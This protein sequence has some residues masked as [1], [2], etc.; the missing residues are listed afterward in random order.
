MRRKLVLLFY[1]A[2]LIVSGCIPVSASGDLGTNTPGSESSL[3]IMP[4]SDFDK[5]VTKAPAMKTTPS[6]TITAVLFIH[7]PH[8]ARPL[9]DGEVFEPPPTLA[10]TPT[11]WE[12][13]SPLQGYPRNR[14]DKIVS[15]PYDPPPMGSDDRH[16]GVDFAYHSLAGVSGSIEGVGV[17]SVMPGYVAT[18]IHNSFPFG[19]LVII[20]TP[21]ALVPTPV[22]QEV[23]L[24]PGFSIYVLYAHLQEKLEVVLGEEVALCQL[25]GYVGRS[26]NT[27]APHLHL[28]MRIG[29]QGAVFE[30]MS[31]YVPGVTKKARENYLLWRISGTFLHFDP[32]RVLTLQW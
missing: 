29:P 17:L 7:T 25:L 14:L 12:L 24:Q 2:G 22:A 5:L 6:P 20:E 21:Y 32:M 13:C 8:G 31:A 28:E 11:P 27:A 10:L 4:G 15:S 19:N 9:F 18:A 3:Y 26:G 23:N 30:E 16:Q 1:C